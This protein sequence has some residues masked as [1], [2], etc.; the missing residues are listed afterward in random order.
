M[1]QL[2]ST[3]T[4]GMLPSAWG[5][6]IPPVTSPGRHRKLD[7][8]AAQHSGSASNG[9]PVFI[10]LGCGFPPV[11]TV[12]TA[13]HMPAWSVFGVDRSFAR[14]VL[15]DAEGHYACF[16]QDGKFQYLQFKWKPLHDNP[17]DA[18]DR[19]VSLFANLA[20]QLNV[21]DDRASVTSQKDGNRLVFNHIRNFE[22]ENLKFVES[23]IEELQLPPARVVRCMNVLLY[24]E[25]SVRQ[26]MR[27]L[28][29][30]LL[31]DDGKLICGFNHPF[32]IY[33]RYAVYQ[34]GATG[35]QLSEFSFSPDNLRP[36]GV[37]PWLTIQEGDEEAELLADLTGAVRADRIFWPEFNRYVDALQEQHGICR[38]SD[39]G[40]NHFTRAVE[41]APPH[42]LLEKTTAL[43]HQLETAGYTDGAVEAL[44]RA[45]YQAWKNPVGHIAVLPPKGSLLML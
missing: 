43:W 45:G 31:D 20:P 21:V 3:V 39:D 35:M 13:R 4:P 40:F 1:I 2:L 24:F 15:Y 8:Y 37:A 30:G 38:R 23:D 34:N 17:K 19:F 5:G 7:A 16:D 14:Y 41:T 11:T 10:D 18:R 26:R 9:Q 29:G 22:A 44:C 6:R 36:L 33:A 42:V 12:D 32:G 28:M 25:K 27:R